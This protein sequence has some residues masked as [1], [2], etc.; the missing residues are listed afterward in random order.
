MKRLFFS[1]LLS[2]AFAA[3]FT[4][5]GQRSLNPQPSTNTIAAP[6]DSVLKVYFWVEGK[7]IKSMN[8]QVVRYENDKA[9]LISYIGTGT[10]IFYIPQG[11]ISGIKTAKK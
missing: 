9:E 10:A 6:K 1:L 11:S 2:A 3:T 8:C 7:G 4:A 5:Y